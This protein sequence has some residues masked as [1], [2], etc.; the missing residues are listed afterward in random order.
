MILEENDND[1]ILAARPQLLCLLSGIK[2]YSVTDN[3]RVATVDL[4]AACCGHGADSEI[5]EIYFRR[6][7]GIFLTYRPNVYRV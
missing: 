6:Y 2:R 4:V 3:N 1:T 7:T 5:F